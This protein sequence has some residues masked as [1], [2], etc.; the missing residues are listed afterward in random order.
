M[1][2][3]VIVL[4]ALITVALC[5]GGDDQSAETLKYVNVVNSDGSYNFEYSSSNGIDFGES[6]VGASYAKGSYSYT[7]PEGQP[8]DLTY[9]ADE[10]GYQPQGDHL[11]TPPPIPA[12]ILKAL[13]YIESHPFPQVNLAKRK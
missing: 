4:S 3:F 13:A 9:T 7:S 2:K 6:G 8:I 10:N 1:F 11:P 5:A 12:Y